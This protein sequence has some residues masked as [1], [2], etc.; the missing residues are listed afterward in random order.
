M[1][2]RNALVTAIEAVKTQ[3]RPSLEGLRCKYK[4]ETDGGTLRCAVGHLVPL[5]VHDDTTVKLGHS[6]EVYGPLEYLD[7][8]GVKVEQEG[9]ANRLYW[10]RALQHVHDLPAK[11]G[12]WSNQSAK[13]DVE[14]GFPYWREAFDR[15]SAV[16]LGMFDENPAKPPSLCTLQDV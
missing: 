3:G 4:H 1:K 2:L 14:A 8:C 9:V 12:N 16:L 10:L 6:L 15:R 5:D 11:G 7:A 13:A